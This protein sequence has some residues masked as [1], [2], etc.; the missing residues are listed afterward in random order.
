MSRWKS[1]RTLESLPN[2]LILTCFDY[3]NSLD[4]IYS[5]GKLN[6]RFDQLI[7]NISLFLHFDNVSKSIFDQICKQIFANRRIQNQIISLRLSNEDNINEIDKFLSLFQLKDFVNL[8]SLTM[9]HLPQYLT[10][11]KL[12]S[13]LSTIPKLNSLSIL[14]TTYIRRMNFSSSEFQTSLSQI[15][16]YLQSPNE[17][18]PIVNLI[19]S[20][21]SFD[22]FDRLLCIT[23]MLKYVKIDE[24]ATNSYS[25]VNK[26]DFNR[27]CTSNLQCLVVYSLGGTSN[28]LEQLFKQIPN[29]KNLKI[30]TPRSNYPINSQ[31]WKDLLGKYLHHLT[32]FQFL[33]YYSISTENL[34]IFLNEV[35]QFQ[36]YF[37]EDKHI[38]YFYNEYF[39]CIYTE[40]YL[41]NSFTLTRD[42]KKSTT[43]KN[44]FIN[45]NDLTINQ[46]MLQEESNYYFPNIQSLTIENHLDYSRYTEQS[47]SFP[48]HVQHL[49]TFVNLNNLKHLD[50]SSKYD[51]N[52]SLFILEIFKQSSKLISL[53]IDSECLAELFEEKQFCPYFS[54]MIKKLAIYTKDGIRNNVSFDTIKNLCRFF[55]NIEQLKCDI[56]DPKKVSFLL[57][58]LTKLQYFTASFLF[59][60]YD[61]EILR[62]WEKRLNYPYFQ[63]KIND[64]QEDFHTR[65]AEIY[66]WIG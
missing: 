31:I 56:Y 36:K 25:M 8:Q 33:F 13:I 62:Q 65:K 41:E 27:S 58:R 23:P 17:I 5:F 42:I 9:K 48:K 29:L 39:D 4:I 63:Y 57:N 66:V 1:I 30:I 51:K 21:C 16:P 55:G 26:E 40:P 2:E 37:G 20:K 59:D 22:E 19:I 18:F 6:S 43:N 24:L 52:L 7:E 28:H 49:Q 14:D 44:T 11:E 35:D 50:I 15:Y 12:H 46:E 47:I 54:R 53:V 32:N 10:G 64:E 38:K 60:E 61:D 34:S 3:L 45:V